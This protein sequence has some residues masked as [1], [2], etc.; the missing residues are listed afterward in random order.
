MLVGAEGKSY[1]AKAFIV[2]STLVNIIIIFF[3]YLSLTAR[4]LIYF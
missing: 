2:F 4:L 1:E 3:F